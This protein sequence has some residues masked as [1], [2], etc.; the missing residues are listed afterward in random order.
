[1]QKAGQRIRGLVVVTGASRGLGLEFVRQ[2]ALAD[3]DVIAC[4][5]NPDLPGLSHLGKTVRVVAMDVTDA[6]SV[7]RMAESLQGRPVDLLI[8][9]A[10]IRGATGG[11]SEVA[12][13]DFLDVM[14]VNVLGPLL[15]TRALLPNLRQGRGVVANIG[16]RA[17]SMVEGIDPDG[18]YAYKCSKAALNMVTVKLADDTG[19]TV[20]SLHPGWVRTDMG[21]P[22]AE[23]DAAESVAALLGLLAKAGT[24]D[25]GSFRAYN[26][27]LV[28]W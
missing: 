11:L 18:D 15:V 24:A 25:R 3:T 1:M 20:L 10:A 12:R 7:S 26:G 6:A 8:N 9:N 17:G 23:L 13:D 16:S 14:A 28:A 27:D 2:L 21:G 5:R 19:L 22:D 4:C